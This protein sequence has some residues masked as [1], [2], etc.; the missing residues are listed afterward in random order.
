MHI[1]HRK[2][3]FILAH[4]LAFFSISGPCALNLYKE[5]LQMKQ[6][7]CRRGTTLLLHASRCNM[8]H[9]WGRD[10]TSAPCKSRPWIVHT[11]GRQAAFGHAWRTRHHITRR[12]LYSWENRCLQEL[13]DLAKLHFQEYSYLNLFNIV[14]TTS[15]HFPSTC[16]NYMHGLKEVRL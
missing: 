9:R 3:F 1:S 14:C 7:P 2:N 12:T 10:K 5:F 8:K 16:Y 15:C 4:R 6:T 11:W 13:V